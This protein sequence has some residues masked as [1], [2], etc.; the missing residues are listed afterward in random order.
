M[1]KTRKNNKNMRRKQRGGV[2]FAKASGPVGKPWDGSNVKSWPGVSKPSQSNYLK[3]NTYE[4]DPVG[5]I[6][7]TRNQKGGKAKKYMKKSCKKGKKSQRKNARKT[8]NKM[9]KVNKKNKTHKQKGGR[10]DSMIPQD[11]VN[12][13]R[14]VE[15]SI[16]ELINNWQGKLP[17]MSPSPVVQPLAV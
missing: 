10:R 14:N 16:N 4:N 9:K 11:L 6:E 12:I 1:V 2:A 5:Y 15:F 17:P 13:G 8:M 3:L 7:S